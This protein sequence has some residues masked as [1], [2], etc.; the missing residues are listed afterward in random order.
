MRIFKTL[1]EMSKEVEREILHNGLIRESST[2]QDKVVLGNDDFTMKELVGYSFM[3]ADTSDRDK[4]LAEQGGDLTWA[5]WDFAERVNDTPVNPGEA[6]KRRDAWAE[7]LHNGKFSYTYSERLNGQID[8]VV[9]LI[10]AA[11][12]TRQ[13]IIQIYDKNID[14]ERRNGTMRIPCSMYYQFL[15]RDGKLDLIYNIRSNDFYE[16]FKY[17]IWHA[18]TLNKYIALKTDLKAGDL[19][20]FAGSLHAFKKDKKE[21]F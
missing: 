12:N 14:N 19:I 3:V 20:Y 5:Q 15:P 17:D 1:G 4:W 13:A 9:D 21:I 10:N 18:A 16:H 6:Y 11:P 7:F 2:V 8:D